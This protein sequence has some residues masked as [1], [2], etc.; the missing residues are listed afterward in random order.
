METLSSHPSLF[1]LTNEFEFFRKLNFLVKSKTTY[2]SHCDDSPPVGIK[3]CF[4]CGFFIFFFKDEDQGGEHDGPHE[5]KEEEEAELLVVG[6]HGVAE[7]LEAGG[8]PRQLED[9]DDPQRLHDSSHFQK[10]EVLRCSTNISLA[11]G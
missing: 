4:E 7:G 9:P 5:E 3:H 1:C 6:L 8:V 2:C 10:P 11:I